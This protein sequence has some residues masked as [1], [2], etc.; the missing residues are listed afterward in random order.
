MFSLTPFPARALAQLPIK[1][2]NIV[3]QQTVHAFPLRAEMAELC[4][5]A[6]RGCG[7]QVRISNTLSKNISNCL[8]LAYALHF[9]ML[10]FSLHKLRT[11]LIKT[12]NGNTPFMFSIVFVLHNSFKHLCYCLGLA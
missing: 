7:D 5:A 1:I 11:E 6:I 9:F 12:V 4:E 10:L 8:G 2:G 3:Q